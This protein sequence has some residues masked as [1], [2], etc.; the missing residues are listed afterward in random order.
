MEWKYWLNYMS[1][2]LKEKKWTDNEDF[3]NYLAQ[4]GIQD[5]YT[6][7]LMM[8]M[9]SP[10]YEYYQ[11]SSYY[12]IKSGVLDYSSEIIDKLGSYPVAGEYSLL[13]NMQILSV[14]I[15]IVGLIFDI[16]LIQFIIISVLLIYSLLMITIETKTFDTGVM[17]LLG[18]SSGGFIVLIFTQALMFV[19][20]SLILGFI[21][22]VPS[23]WY[24]Y[25]KLESEKQPWNLDLLPS[26]GA[27]F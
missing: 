22:V 2:Y 4:D 24:I 20:P 26:W 9:P 14:G 5:E 19:L 11:Y 12:K 13:F 18:L 17:R 15:L 7:M 21:G 27:T 25:S 10:R 8:T 6:P 3:M 23:L 1:K 16:M